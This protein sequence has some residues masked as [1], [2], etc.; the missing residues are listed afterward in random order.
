MWTKDKIMLIFYMRKIEKYYVKK[1]SKIENRAI[2]KMVN[3]APH[4]VLNSGKNSYQVFEPES[5]D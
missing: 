1:M 5:K 2:C 4:D 3:S